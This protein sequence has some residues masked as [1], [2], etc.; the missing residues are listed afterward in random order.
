MGYWTV[1]SLLCLAI[2]WFGL[3]VWFQQDDFAWLRLDRQLHETG[4][5]WALLFAPR[6]AGFLAPV[7][8]IANGT[9]EINVV[10]PA[11]KPRPGGASRDALELPA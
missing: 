7:F 1:P 5:L 4:D 2:Y 3:R 9:L 6:A 10:Y 11:G 8:W